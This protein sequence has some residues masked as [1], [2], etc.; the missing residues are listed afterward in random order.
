MKIIA[1]FILV[2]LM[3]RVLISIV[4]LLLK[5]RLPDLKTDTDALVSIMIPARNEAGNI[6]TLLRQIM[7]N[8]YKNIEILVYDDQSEDETPSIIKAFADQDSRI[9][10][11]PG[12]KLPEGWLGKN[13]ACYQLAQKANGDYFL[14]LDADVRITANLIQNAVSYLNKYRL[15]LLSIFPEQKMNSFSERIT[16]P[17]M[18]WILTS[19]LPLPLIKAFPHASLAAANGQFM[20]FEKSN[21]IRNNWHRQFRKIPVEDINIMRA[22]KKQKQKGHTLLSNGQIFCRMYKSYSAAINGFSNNIHE[23]FG[24]NYLV[25][26]LFT[27]ITTFGIIPVIYATSIEGMSVYLFL[28]A[29]LR[30]FTSIASR[31]NPLLNIILAPIQQVSLVVINFKS[32]TNKTRGYAVW[33]GRRLKVK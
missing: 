7:N 10:L 11:I 19:L 3:S 29:L 12:Q 31:Q 14:F 33:K 30:L 28:A 24:K 4:N 8:K 2:F 23:Y 17:V 21:Y 9:M 25:M 22:I 16:V 15:S 6:G 20:L 27:L 26:T 1:G 5:T 18:N 32:L 13:H